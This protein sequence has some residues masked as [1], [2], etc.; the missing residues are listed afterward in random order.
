MSHFESLRRFAHTLAT[1]GVQARAD[2]GRGARLGG[3]ALKVVTVPVGVAIGGAVGAYSRVLTNADTDSTGV[4]LG[5]LKRLKSAGDAKGEVVLEGSITMKSSP[6]MKSL[7]FIGATIGTVLTGAV[8][9][10]AYSLATGGG[11]IGVPE[12]LGVGLVGGIALWLVGS[13]ATGAWAG[14]KEGFKGGVGAANI[15]ARKIEVFFKG[16]KAPSPVAP[17]QSFAQRAE[18][19]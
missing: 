3:T 13:L 17:S 14:I 5:T 11:L 4:V 18:N 1:D 10:D 7:G 9:Y 16:D 6:G 8:G 2:S 12:A 15:A 19:P